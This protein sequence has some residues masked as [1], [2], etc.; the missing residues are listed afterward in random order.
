MKDYTGATT[1]KFLFEYVLTRF[2]Y[3]KVLMS[4]RGMHF[5]NEMISALNEEFQVYHQKSTPYHPQA[6]GIVEAFNKILENMLMKACNMQ[7][8]DWDVH[9]LAMLWVC[10]T[11]CRKLIGQTLFRFVNGIEAM[12][13]MEYIMPSLRI[14]TF[15]GVADRETLEEWLAQLMEFEEYRFLARFHEKIQKEREKAWHDQHIKLTC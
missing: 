7:Q 2:G 8:N 11:T 3:P 15:T 10:R 13:P 14:T 1:T 12:I 4:D 6:N 5:L 9:I